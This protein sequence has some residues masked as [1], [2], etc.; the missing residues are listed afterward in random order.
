MFQN[1]AQYDVT[2]YFFKIVLKRTYIHKTTYV[3]V[4]QRDAFAHF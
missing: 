2:K 1:N 4:L 3:F